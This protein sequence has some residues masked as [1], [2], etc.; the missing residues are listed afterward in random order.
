M[1][2]MTTRNIK[3]TIEYDGTRY[4]GWQR[5]KGDRTLQGE[6]EN[7]LATM[8]GQNITLIGSGRTD[9]GVHAL[10]Q[11]A[12]FQCRAR[13]TPEA[14]QKGL[15]S[16]LDDDIV[17]RECREVPL[18]FHARF[19]ARS[20]T[21]HY[22][23]LNRSLPSAMDRLYVW[24]IR[25]PLDLAAMEDAASRL[26]GEHDFKAFEGA[27]SPRA[28]TRRR[29][30]QAKPMSEPFGMVVFKIQAEGFL[31]YMVRNIVGTLAD[32]GIGKITPS[33][34]Q[35]ILESGDR[36]RAGATA[37][38]RGLFLMHVDYEEETENELIPN[39]SAARGIIS[40]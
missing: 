1:A 28:H 8:T 31:R 7:A 6:I 21:Y 32:V 2:H 11:T 18:R 39:E 27:G 5:Q 25:R 14:F 34:F 23:I 9:A 15:N 19:D 33:D 17:I 10:G 26:L 13:L 24:H 12:N 20:K 38:P 29:V 22:R 36:G 30:F 40:Q 35:D 37:P 16:L 3:L 4:H